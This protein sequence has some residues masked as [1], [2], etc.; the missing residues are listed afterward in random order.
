ESV[1]YRA[2]KMMGGY[3]L[4][5]PDQHSAEAVHVLFVGEKSKST[6]PFP[7][8]QLDPE[9]KHL[10]GIHIPVAPLSDLLRMKLN[11]LGPKDLI[12]IETLDEVGL[13]TGA[14]EREL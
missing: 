2:K 13:I 8:P 6:Q 3:M 4:I 14:L 11:S 7:H 5:R 9:E 12:D 10:F 1:G